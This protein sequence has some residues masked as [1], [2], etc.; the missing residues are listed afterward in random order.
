MLSVSQH[1]E[2][3]VK[4]EESLHVPTQGDHMKTYISKCITKISYNELNIM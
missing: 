2:E 1:C 4:E 3:L